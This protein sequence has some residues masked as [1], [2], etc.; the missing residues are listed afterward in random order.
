[1]VIHD[2]VHEHARQILYRAVPPETELI[3]VTPLWGSFLVKVRFH[4][5][6]K[7]RFGAIVGDVP[8]YQFFPTWREAMIHLIAREQG[9]C[10]EDALDA[11]A[12]VADLLRR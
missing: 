2:V 12:E 5:S 6:R 7:T 9:L 11:V 4:H 3:E 10:P 8:P 1:M